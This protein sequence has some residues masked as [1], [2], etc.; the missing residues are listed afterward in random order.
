MASRVSVERDESRRGGVIRGGVIRGGVIRGGVIRDGRDREEIP[1]RN[2]NSR[3][4]ALND[5]P[6]MFIPQITPISYKCNI[7]QLSALRR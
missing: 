3:I 6:T 7:T 4:A 1:M 5:R 2:L